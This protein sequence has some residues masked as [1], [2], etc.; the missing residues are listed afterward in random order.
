[1]RSRSPN[2]DLCYVPQYTVVGHGSGCSTD[3]ERTEVVERAGK[4]AEHAGFARLLVCHDGESVR[5]PY[6]FPVGSLEIDTQMERE[7]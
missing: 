7:G 4:C 3:G 6:Q 5:V 2:N 1:M